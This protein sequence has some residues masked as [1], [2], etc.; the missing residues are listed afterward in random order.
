ALEPFRRRIEAQHRLRAPLRSPDLVV[1]VDVH[2]VDV[3]VVAR[4]AP[5]A[6]LAGRGLVPGEIAGVPFRDPDVAL[7]VGPDA[8]RALAR[9]RR[10]DH[11]GFAA[12]KIDA[13]DVRT[14]ER[15]VV[16]V[17]VGRDVNAVRAATAR[18]LEHFHLAV[19]RVEPAVDAALA[20]KPVHALLVE[21]RRVEVGVAAV[22]GQRPAL[23][24]AGLRIDAHDRVLP[25]V[26]EEGRAV[27]A[28]D[29]AVRRGAGAELDELDLAALGVE[30]AEV[31][32]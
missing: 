19:A 30:D 13:G 6:P 4:R 18:R 16:H 11:R 3:R 12:A 14:G 17:A 25:A 7:G 26:G 9:R 5:R 15:G 28:G 31:A 21:D 2:R 10:L 22:R 8:A 32:A 27:G 23:H 29:H 20:G 24:G 1:L